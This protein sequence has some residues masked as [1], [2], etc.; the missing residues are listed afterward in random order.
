MK[1]FKKT[2]KKKK[3]SGRGGHHPMPLGRK[4]VKEKKKIW[5]MKENEK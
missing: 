4:F 3:I 5:T 2:E 1:D